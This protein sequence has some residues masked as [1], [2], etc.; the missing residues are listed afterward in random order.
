MRLTTVPLKA[1]TWGLRLRDRA[2]H[3]TS[4]A[5]TFLIP[6]RGE[7]HA[8]RLHDEFEIN[9]NRALL[10]VQKVKL[11]PLIKCN[12]I[13]VEARLPVTCHTWFNE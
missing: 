11:R 2:S 6:L 8:N 5:S 9:P 1:I 3:V 13:A 10:D 7:H 12:V 4:Y